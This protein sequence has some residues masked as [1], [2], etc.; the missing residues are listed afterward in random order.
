MPATAPPTAPDTTPSIHRALNGAGSAVPVAPFT[1]VVALKRFLQEN[2]YSSDLQ[3]AFGSYLHFWG[4]ASFD[5]VGKVP[6]TCNSGALSSFKAA[7]TDLYAYVDMTKQSADVDDVFVGDDGYTV[8][9]RTRWHGVCNGAYTFQDGTTVDLAG[10]TFA[11]WRSS[12]KLTFGRA[13]KKVEKF[14]GLADLREWGRVLGS[15]EFS[16]NVAVQSIYPA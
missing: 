14:D 2:V 3:V 13:S 1:D 5:E 10:K 9:V 8:L 7:W 12:Y 15:P 11:N 16:R 4:A 6:A